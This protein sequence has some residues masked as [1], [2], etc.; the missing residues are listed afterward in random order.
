MKFDIFQFS[1]KHFR[2]IFWVIVATT[3]PMTAVMIGTFLGQ[4]HS[5]TFSSGK[6][7][8]VE[9]I[10]MAHAI[11]SPIGIVALLCAFGVIVSGDRPRDGLEIGFLVVMAILAFMLF[12]F[13]R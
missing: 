3:I 5:K 8:L 11:A 13:L 2:T 6:S 12:P 4:G 9:F 10:V 7:A 1:A